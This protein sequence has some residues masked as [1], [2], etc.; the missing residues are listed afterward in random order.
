[1]EDEPRSVFDDGESGKMSALAL[2]ARDTNH[3]VLDRIVEYLRNGYFR[4]CSTI[5]ERPA[6]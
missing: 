4:Q 6:G 2:V 5:G 3:G 1:M